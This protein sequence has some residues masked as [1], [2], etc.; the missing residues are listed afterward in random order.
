MGRRTRA[1]RRR[2][3]AARKPTKA[4]TPRRRERARKEEVTAAEAAGFEMYKEAAPSRVVE[5][6]ARAGVRGEVTQI[7]CK[8]LAG[9]DAGKVLRRNVKGPV[10]IGDI[11][12]I[13][14]T[15]MEAA[16]L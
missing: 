3:L 5:I 7:R 14:D 12:M 4:R 13:K 15:E 6:I 1:V 10:R 16:P 11:L 8:I 2:D 9:R